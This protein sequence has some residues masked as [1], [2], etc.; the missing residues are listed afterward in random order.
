MSGS[1]DVHRLAPPNDYVHGV[2][3]AAY[4]DP[5]PFGP[6]RASARPRGTSAAG[7]PWKRHVAL[8][9]GLEVT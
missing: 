3:R 6:D 7:V 2:R 8:A 5:G 9:P 4:G 1:V